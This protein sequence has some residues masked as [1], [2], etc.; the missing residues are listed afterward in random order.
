MRNQHAAAHYIPMR[1]SKYRRQVVLILANIGV[2]TNIALHFYRRFDGISLTI[3]TLFFTHF[4]C[5][6]QDISNKYL[7]P[8]WETIARRSQYNIPTSICTTFLFVITCTLIT[9]GK[10]TQCAG[11]IRQLCTQ[12]IHIPTINIQRIPIIQKS[13]VKYCPRARATKQ[14][15]VHM[16]LRTNPA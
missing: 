3:L 5:L 1:L 8:Y 7:K 11:L 15:T 16:F 2:T 4:R 6:Q 13:H 10:H 14:L 12:L 9:S